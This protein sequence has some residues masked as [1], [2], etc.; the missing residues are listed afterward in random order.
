MCGFSASKRRE[1]P[2]RGS[3]LP[4]NFAQGE[5]GLQLQSKKT[6]FNVIPALLIKTAGKNIASYYPHPSLSGLS[7]GARSL[8]IGGRITF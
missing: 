4:F 7:S 8:Q 5:E 6:R 2:C 3:A 1:R